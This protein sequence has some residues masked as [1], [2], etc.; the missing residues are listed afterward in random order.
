MLG[1]ARRAVPLACTGAL[2]V[3]SGCDSSGTDGSD[4]KKELADTRDPFYWKPRKFHI[5][6]KDTAEWWAVTAIHQNEKRR[7]TRKD[8]DLLLFDRDGNDGWK[9]VAHVSPGHAG[10]AP[11]KFARDKDGFVRTV[12]PRK[13]TGAIAPSALPT[14]LAELTTLR[15]P[16][17]SAPFASTK[18]S[19]K[20]NKTAKGAAKSLG[21]GGAVTYSEGIIQ[22]TTAYALATA[23]GKTFAVFNAGIDSESSITRPGLKIEPSAIDALYTG[24]KRASVVTSNYLFQASALIPARGKPELLGYGS[25]QVDADNGN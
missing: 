9:M 22:H 6:R 18:L 12:D 1:P 25:E 21:E 7:I 19:H 10:E 5:P 23:D 17:S 4:T 11:V 16:I 24:R 15:G 13:K 3:L 8:Q 14:A 2:L 20:L